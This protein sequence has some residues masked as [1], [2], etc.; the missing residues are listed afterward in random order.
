MNRYFYLV[1]RK[2]AMSHVA[3]SYPSLL[4]GEFLLNASLA[5][6]PQNY[7]ADLD[8]LHEH[9]PSLGIVILRML[10]QISPLHIGGL[11][12]I[13]EDCTPG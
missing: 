9:F 5:L 6:V 8:Q 13:L 4:R 1:A 10:S 12:P 3:N 11:F 7:R 2:A